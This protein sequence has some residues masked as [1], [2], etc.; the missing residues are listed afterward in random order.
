MKCWNWWIS[1]ESDLLYD[2]I[3]DSANIKMNFVGSAGYQY[4][5]NTSIY[6]RLSKAYVIYQCLLSKL[7]MLA[8]PKTCWA[9]YWMEKGDLFRRLSFF[10][11][12]DECRMTHFFIHGHAHL[13]TDSKKKLLE[14][15]VWFEKFWWIGYKKFNWELEQVV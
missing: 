3:S 15:S 13:K 9:L 7:C 14:N 4:L 12:L 11:L 2:F 1:G 10:N 6:Q 5:C 8:V